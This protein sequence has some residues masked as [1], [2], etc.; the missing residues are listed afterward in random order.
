MLTHRK[1]RHKYPKERGSMN[2]NGMHLEVIDLLYGA[3]ALE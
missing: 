1:N 3:V 2:K